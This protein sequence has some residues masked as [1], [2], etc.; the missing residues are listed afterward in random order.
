MLLYLPTVQ[1]EVTFSDDE[2][3]L[4]LGIDDPPAKVI[5]KSDGKASGMMSSLFG[6]SESVEK[7]LQRPGTA[8]SQNSFTVDAKSQSKPGSIAHL[9]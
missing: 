3:D 8:G 1:E 2:D 9:I 7:H 6:R 4:D 5:D